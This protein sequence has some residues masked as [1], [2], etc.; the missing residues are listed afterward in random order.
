MSENPEFYSPRYNDMPD[1][2]TQKLEAI[3]E[4]ARRLE[5]QR[6]VDRLL[7]EMRDTGI[8]PDVTT[9][10]VKYD[11]AKP[12]WSLVPLDALEMVARVMTYGAKKYAPDGWKGLPNFTNRYY[13]ALLR[14]LTAWQAG[15]QFDP[16]SGLPHMAHVLTNA[17][18]LMW[19]E[20]EE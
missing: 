11:E 20:L 1:K 17:T 7:E 14:H 15:E 19:G 16:E 8:T 3:M 4:S 10:A 9:G 6:E 18:F 2:L 12:D 13:A 5:T